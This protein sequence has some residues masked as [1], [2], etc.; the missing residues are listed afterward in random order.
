LSFVATGQRQLTT[1]ACEDSEQ[2]SEQVGAIAI[3]TTQGFVGFKKDFRKAFKK[4][5]F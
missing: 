5:E 4:S 3:R 2:L 1:A